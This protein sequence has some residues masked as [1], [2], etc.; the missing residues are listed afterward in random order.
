MNPFMRNRNQNPLSAGFTLIELL[1]VIAIISILAALLLPALA[2]AK[3]K[4]KC[5]Q[6]MNNHSQ[7]GKAAFMYRDDH[8]DVYPY[9]LRCSG[10]GTGLG[11]VLDPNGWPMQFLHYLG[12]YRPTCQPAIYVCPSERRAASFYWAFQVHYQTSRPL[13]ERYEVVPRIT[14]AMLRKTSIYW[15]FIEK[16]P[17][18]FCSISPGGLANPVL[19]SWNHAPGSPGYRRHSGSMT[20]TAADGHIERL[21]TPPYRPCA[22]P[23][24]NFLE[25]GDCSSGVNPASTWQDPTT[26]GDHNGG[27]VKLWTRHSQGLYGQPLF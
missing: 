21:R 27:R 8:D 15:M 14:G 13:R 25:L 11:S 6:C 9:S 18:G 5:I 4:A 2:K 12:D 23:P 7:I 10:P 16:E 3:D 26:P 24:R 19:A 22:P 1:V 20:A 17:E